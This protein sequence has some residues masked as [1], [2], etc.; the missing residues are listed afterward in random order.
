MSSI[1]NTNILSQIA[2]NNLQ[3]TQSSL[4]SAVTDLS[5]GLKINSAADDA[6]G[7][8]ISDRMTSQI[9]GLTA[10]QQN[11]TDGIALAQTAG[12]ALTQITANLQRIRELAVQASNSTYSASDRESM[13]EEVQQRLSE[14]NR[15]ASQT[16]YNGLNLLDG[17]FGV[18]SFQVGAN[19]GQTISV[20]LSSSMKTSQI[21]QTSETTLQIG[22]GTDQNL[23]SGSLAIQLGSGTTVAIGSATSGADEGQSADSAYAAA[24]AISGSDISGLSV[25]A[26]NTQNVTVATSVAAATTISVNGT[27]VYEAGAG[28]LS[29]GDLING[30]NAQSSTTG[31]TATEN[32]DGTLSLTAADGR[33]IALTDSASQGALTTNQG[34]VT[35]SSQTLYG[36]VTLSSSSVIG[37]SGSDATSLSV[38][39]NLQ[40]TGRAVDSSTSLSGTT[41]TSFTL[42]G[43][44]VTTGTTWNAA[45]L[46]AAINAAHISNVV[47]SADSSGHLQLESFSNAGIT[48]TG[49]SPV[50]SDSGLS[51]SQTTIYTASTANSSLAT[52][53]VLTVAD[54]QQTLLAVDSALDEVDSLQG[55]LGAVQNRFSSTITNIQS[56]TQNAQSAQSDIQDADYAAEAS[57]LSRAQVLQQAGTAMVAQANSLPQNVLK[58][59]QQ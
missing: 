6:A 33:N 3:N 2:Q 1:I 15:I 7:L 27:E 26:T 25:T 37:L 52:A 58:L 42:N 38:G 40:S 35:S 4:T 39:T 43:T 17:S 50:V 47:A 51:G 54:A 8:A 10:A 18:A 29:I 16:Q 32:A 5:S 34:A 59:L 20:D 46:A 41:A 55:E 24:A 30:I 19:A 49:S 48:L 22:A 23:S 57:D 11:A 9:N 14:I 12:S 53:D 28:S 21:G 56:A 44:V 45:D 31:V 36:T 13:N